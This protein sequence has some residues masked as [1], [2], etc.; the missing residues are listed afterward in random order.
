MDVSSAALSSAVVIFLV[1]VTSNLHPF[2]THK[3]DAGPIRLATIAH[4]INYRVAV[5]RDGVRIVRFPRPIRRWLNWTPRR[6]YWTSHSPRRKWAIPWTRI[7]CQSCLGKPGWQLRYWRDLQRICLRPDIDLKLIAA[8]RQDATL[9]T[10]REWVQS[11]VVPAWSDCAGLSPELR[12]WRLQIG[13]MSV[14]TEWR[15]WRRR[16]PPSGASQLVVPGRERQDMIRRFNDSLLPA[17]WV[18]PKQFIVYRI[19]YIGWGCF[20]MFVLTW[21]HVLFV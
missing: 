8:S 9:T 5:L 7:C 4:A 11:G 20:R 15:L 16:A 3:L 12:C 21:H 14:D 2:F 19:G 18:F 17:I 13:N 1:D 6:C 10:V